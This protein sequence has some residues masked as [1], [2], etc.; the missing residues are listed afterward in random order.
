MVTAVA[1]DDAMF[2]GRSD[3]YLS[4]GLSALH[5]INGVVAE[6]GE[7]ERILDLPCG[8]GR[9]TR[10]LRARFPEA[11][12]TA[13]DIDRSGVDF[14]AAHF[15]ARGVMSV[16]DFRQLDL[17]GRYDLIWVGSLLT[18]LSELQTRRFLDCAARHM[19]AGAILVVTSH[20]TFV[21]QRMLSWT[22]GLTEQ[23]ACGLLADSAVNGYGFRNYPGGDGYG[24]SLAQRGWFETLFSDGPFELVSYQPAGWDDHQDVLALRRREA[25]PALRR[26]WRRPAAATNWFERGGSPASDAAAQVLRDQAAVTGFDEGFYLAAYPD[27]ADAVAKGAWASGLAHFMAYGWREARRFCGP[28][29]IFGAHPHGSP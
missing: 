17:G 3:H 18:H 14:S 26:S 12:L 9:V 19:A 20:G 24:I 8:H 28:D 4:V 15:G 22:Y 5:A 27:V 23:A 16:Q 21:A 13:C 29:R 2:D 11:A 7:P 10:V 6:L 1:D 25:A